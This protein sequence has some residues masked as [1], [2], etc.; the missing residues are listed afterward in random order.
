MGV[1]HK[2]QVVAGVVFHNWSPEAGVIE[3]SCAAENK[4]WMTRGVMRTALGYVFDLLECQSAVARTAETNITV[5]KLWKALGAQEYVIPR[6]RGVNE[7]E[8]ILVLPKEAWMDSKFMR[9]A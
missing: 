2:G 8:A 3:L 5:R 6:L 4:R 9:G 1:E 7:A